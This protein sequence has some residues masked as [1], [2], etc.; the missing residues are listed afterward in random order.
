MATDLT[1]LTLSAA[2]GL[3]GSVAKALDLGTP[4]QSIGLSEALTF[5]FGTGAGKAN[6]IWHDRRTLAASANEELDLNG[7]LENPFG[8][9]VS[10]ANI[11]GILVINRSDEA[12]G[13]HTATDAEIA[14]GGA[15][16]AEFLGPFQAAGDKLGV[17]AGGVFL[18]ATPDASGWTVAGDYVSTTD[19]LKITNLDGADEALYDIYL[20]GESQ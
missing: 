2:V 1:A 4:T 14:I 5:A 13:A 7:S 19:K 16:S 17:P 6:Q 9:V 12:L 10:F 8:Q 15:A 3:N 18:I 20:W 11:K